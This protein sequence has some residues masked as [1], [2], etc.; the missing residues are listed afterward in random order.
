MGQNRLLTCRGASFASWAAPGSTGPRSIQDRIPRYSHVP[1]FP[2][3]GLPVLS[4]PAGR[5]PRRPARRPGRAA[6]AC[7][8]VTASS[9]DHDPGRR[10]DLLHDRLRDRP[11]C[12]VR[13]ANRHSERAVPER[14]ATRVARRL[15]DSRRGPGRYREPLHGS[16]PVD[17][18]RRRQD[19]PAAEANRDRGGGRHRRSV[20]VG[21][22]GHRRLLPVSAAVSGTGRL[23]LGRLA[24]SRPRP[25][26]GRHRPSQPT[27][28]SHGLLSREG[29]P[30]ESGLDDAGVLH[31]PAALD[32]P[33]RG[34][35]NDAGRSVPRSGRRHRS[36]ADA[37]AGCFARDR[38][39]RGQL[40]A[41]S[42][43]ATSSRMDR[44]SHERP[45]RSTGRPARATSGRTRFRSSW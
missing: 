3:P 35:W 18:R 7:G 23:W 33:V 24:G 31:R 25:P 26:P 22:A 43:S 37:P 9:S 28:R 40:R 27:D 45:S 11:G 6:V 39:W 12:W 19:H 17:R 42:V 4:H 13:L 41:T 44:T 38:R 10:A 16:A 8:G 34:R 2:G 14:A 20:R 5:R 1:R 29:H 15:A 21:R 36:R 30:D 32:L